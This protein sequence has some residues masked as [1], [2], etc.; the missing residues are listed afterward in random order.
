MRA[1]RIEQYGG[2]EV[3]RRVDIDVPSP[4]DGELL[5]RVAC[6][7]V[8]I[9]AAI[10]D[11]ALDAEITGRYTLDRVEIAHAALEERRQLGK[12]ILLIA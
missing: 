1:I 10:R 2:P 6:A 8:K 5:V 11:G 3:L 12:S 4:G 7:G 9:F